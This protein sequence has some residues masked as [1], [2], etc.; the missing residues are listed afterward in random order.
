MVKSRR[1]TICD[2]CALNSGRYE[3]FDILANTVVI[4]RKAV[5]SAK[6]TI[7]DTCALNSRSYD[8]SDI[9][10]HTT[11]WT[12]TSKL[13]YLHEISAQVSQIVSLTD[14]TILRLI[15]NNRS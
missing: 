11:I 14:L 10:A 2:T 15:Y 6:N 7:C 9:L 13:S 1:N 8:F 4:S 12:K 5:K 3:F